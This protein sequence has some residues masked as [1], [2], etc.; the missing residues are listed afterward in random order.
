LP[1]LFSSTVEYAFRAIVTLASRDGDSVTA[2]ELAEVTK[3]PPGYVSKVMQTLVD[4]KLVLAKRGPNGGFTLARP[5]QQITL[6]DVIQ[7]VD[8]LERITSCPL[9]LPEHA[10]K[11][12]PLHRVMDEVIE[13]DMK[14]LQ[15]HTIAALMTQ[16]PASVTP[17]Q[18]TLGGKKMSAGAK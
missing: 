12:C 2:R 14:A 13:A 8:P 9:G 17:M 15:S 11:L 3:S 1:N 18:L 5:P 4:G 7:A 16:P 10:T 6:L